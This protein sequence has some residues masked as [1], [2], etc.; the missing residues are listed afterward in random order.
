MGI[1]KL[2]A[3]W[4]FRSRSLAARGVRASLGGSIGCLAPVTVVFELCTLILWGQFS[5]PAQREGGHPC[6]DVRTPCPSGPG[7][8]LP[9][10]R[11]ASALRS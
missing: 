8:C 2:V 4:Q 10:D 7:Q 11:E 6:V 1:R 9:G 3:S 5:V